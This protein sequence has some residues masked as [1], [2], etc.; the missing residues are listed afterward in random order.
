MVWPVTT[1]SCSSDIHDTT[2][3]DITDYRIWSYVLIDFRA[4]W[5]YCMSAAVTLLPVTYHT[6]ISTDIEMR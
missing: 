2:T 6:D 3:I 1:T 5:C 4:L